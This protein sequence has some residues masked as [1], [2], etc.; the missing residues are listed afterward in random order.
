MIDLLGQA[1]AGDGTLQT[2]GK[3]FASQGFYVSTGY[4][5]SQSKLFS[6]ECPA[7]YKNLEFLFRYEQY[8]NVE[9]ADPANP[10]RTNVFETKLYTGGINYYIEG[11]TKIQLNYSSIRNPDG[12]SSAPYTFHNP[13]NNLFL[14]NFQVAF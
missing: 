11:N 2:N 12:G 4:K 1:N 8:Q 9:I 13:R 6:C 7:W 5:L 10:S 3:P 14:V